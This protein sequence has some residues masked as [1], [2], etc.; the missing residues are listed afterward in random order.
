MSPSDT[1]LYD[2]SFCRA[3]SAYHHPTSDRK[4]LEGV[5]QECY[6]PANN[7]Q[8]RPPHQGEFQ[9]AY[10]ETGSAL[11]TTIET[12]IKIRACWCRA[13]LIQAFCHCDGGRQMAFVP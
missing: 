9:A 10:N 8:F 13:I 11:T 2:D 7:P 3:L 4:L 5:P 1:T 6:C 12:P